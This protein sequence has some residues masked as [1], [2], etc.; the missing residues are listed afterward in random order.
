MDQDIWTALDECLR[1]LDQD[2]RCA[3]VE[4]IAMLI[5]NNATN[6]R[7]YMLQQQRFTN[8]DVS[9]VVSVLDWESWGRGF[10][11]LHG[12]NWFL[13]EKESFF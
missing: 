13:F 9:R 10:D 3:A 8:R 1:S 6:A 11:S 2:T 5:D 4:I 12:G 7:I